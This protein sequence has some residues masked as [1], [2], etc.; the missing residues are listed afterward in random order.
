MSFDDILNDVSGGLNFL[1]S[2]NESEEE[3]RA[4]VSEAKAAGVKVFRTPQPFR[5]D[6]QKTPQ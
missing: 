5:E 4:P 6:K 2:G 1:S 3:K